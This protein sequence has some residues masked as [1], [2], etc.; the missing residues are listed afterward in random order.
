MASFDCSMFFSKNKARST[1][2][3]HVLCHSANTKQHPFSVVQCQAL[4]DVIQRDAGASLLHVV[5]STAVF[6]NK[7]YVGYYYPMTQ[8]CWSNGVIEDTVP[9]Y[10]KLPW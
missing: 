6:K 1:Q 9:E 4:S 7:H 8:D 5:Y 2:L 3:Q 10:D